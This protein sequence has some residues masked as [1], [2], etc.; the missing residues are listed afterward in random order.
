VLYLG[1]AAPTAEED[2]AEKAADALLEDELED[3]EVKSSNREVSLVCK[4]LIVNSRKKNT[5]EAEEERNG[6]EGE[7][8]EAREREGSGPTRTLT[9]Y[10]C[11]RFTLIGLLFRKKSFR[12]P[13]PTDPA[14][15]PS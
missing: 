9:Q 15:I 7:R 10:A 11:L 8:A 12:C 6:E 4:N 3:V 14:S 1:E 5:V 13:C 2:R